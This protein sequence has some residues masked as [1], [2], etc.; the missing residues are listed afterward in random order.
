MNARFLGLSAVLLAGL[1]AACNGNAVPI[2]FASRVI[3]TNTIEQG[4]QLYGQYC[5]AC[6]G[7]DGQGQFPDA[8]LVPDSTGRYGAPPHDDGGH[9]WHHGDALLLQIVREGGMGD[10][11]DFYPMPPF[12]TQLSDDQIISIIAYLKT[13][14]TD[15]HRANQQRR[16]E[17]EAEA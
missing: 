12:S 9:T 13:M 6:H 1:L 10:P 16:T 5:A 15:D 2:T 14:W 3:D 11:K 8:P 17:A 4:R 7:V